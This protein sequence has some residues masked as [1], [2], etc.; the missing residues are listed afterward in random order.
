M[1]RNQNEISAK[2]IMLLFLVIIT[3]LSMREGLIGNTNWYYIAFVSLP[4]SILLLLLPNQSKSRS[5]H[6]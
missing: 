2:G 6:K 1:R 3:A 4:A 5:N